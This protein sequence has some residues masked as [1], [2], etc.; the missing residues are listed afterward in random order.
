MS[1]KRAFE[2][3]LKEALKGSLKSLKRRLCVIEPSRALKS[4]KRAFKEP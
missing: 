4:L 1:L 3:A 2:R